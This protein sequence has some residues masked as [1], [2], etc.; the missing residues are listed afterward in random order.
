MPAQP[1]ELQARLI[2]LFGN[3]ATADPT[4]LYGNL[5]VN[6]DGS[7]SIGTTLT[8]PDGYTRGVTDMGRN[9]VINGA[10]S[11][12]Q[13]A[14]SVASIN[15][16]GLYG[17][18]DRYWFAEIG[19]GAFTQSTGTITYGGVVKQA[20]VQTVTT[21][22]ASYTA[23][24][25]F[26]GFVQKIE[27][28]NCYDMLGQPVAISF[29]FKASVAGTYSVSLQDGNQ[30]NSYLTTFTVA[31]NTP[32]KIILNYPALPTTLNTFANN[33][34][35]MFI[36]I[37][38]L[39]Q[40]TFM[41]STLNQFVSGNY[42]SAS[43]VTNWGATNGN[44]IA[45]TELQFETGTATP[46]ER[47]TYPMVLNQCMRYY[48]R[49]TTGNYGVGSQNS[50]TLSYV[51][52]TF[53]IPKRAAPSVSSSAVGT[54]YLYNG[55]GNLAVTAL[56]WPTSTIRQVLASVTHGSSGASGGAAVLEDQSGSY[57][58]IISEL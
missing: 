40:G 52:I 49:L 33:S 23:G 9:R 5:T 42:I 10:M 45:M 47:L 43:G 54:F 46:F 24:N 29:I 57:I 17:G 2:D 35:G 48:E 44:T 53:Q 36:W 12:V 1:T 8:M 27:G 4:K 26:S 51:N 58:E 38:T 31:A 56:S 34:V 32:T 18:P 28:F 22:V 21:A 20:I 7:V 25:Y 50:A 6:P 15:G 3:P 14:T 11:V 39:N 55:N 37:G 19:A 16:S 13:R 41:G 30:A